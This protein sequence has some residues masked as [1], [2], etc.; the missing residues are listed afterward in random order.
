LIPRINPGACTTFEILGHSKKFVRPKISQLYA[1]LKI[2]Q[3]LK[4]VKN[5]IGF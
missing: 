2:Y 4:V 1:K 3:C 5:V